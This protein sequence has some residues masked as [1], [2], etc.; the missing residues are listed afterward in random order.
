MRCLAGVPGSGEG[1]RVVEGSVER[2]GCCPK[3]SVSCH[4][5]LCL[6]AGGQPAS[7]GAQGVR[8]QPGELQEAVCPQ[9]MEGVSG[10]KGGGLR[11]QGTQVGSWF[12][13]GSPC[14]FS[15]GT[16]S[17]RPPSALFQHCLLVQ[18]PHP[19]PDEK[20]EPEAR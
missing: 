1:W 8:G 5:L 10:L 17:S 16:S 13:P 14:T 12:P 15:P 11:V 19:L 18:P 20:G 3:L 4:A 6:P 7:P 9:T 2:G